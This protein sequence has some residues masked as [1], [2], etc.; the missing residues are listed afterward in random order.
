MNEDI[1]ELVSG[2]QRHVRQSTIDRYDWGEDL[3]FVKS[4]LLFVE[5]G[6][7]VYP[8]G[9]RGAHRVYTRIPS[10]GAPVLVPVKCPSFSVGGLIFPPRM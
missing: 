8:L 2:H 10:M 5:L 6:G 9:A 4:K 3:P 7:A 1:K